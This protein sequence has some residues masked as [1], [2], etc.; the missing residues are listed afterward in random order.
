MIPPHCA[1]CWAAYAPVI[2]DAGLLDTVLDI[3]KGY[4]THSLLAGHRFPAESGKF[5]EPLLDEAGKEIMWLEN[6]AFVRNTAGAPSDLLRHPD[7]PPGLA[8]RLVGQCKHTLTGDNALNDAMLQE[9][10][11]TLGVNATSS[12]V[13][14]E[15]QRQRRRLG[16]ARRRQRHTQV[17]SSPGK[18]LALVQPLRFFSPAL[19]SRAQLAAAA[20]P[21]VRVNTARM[22]EL[23]MWHGIGEAMNKAAAQQRQERA[24][25]LWWGFR[26]RVPRFPKHLELHVRF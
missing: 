20:V 2:G 10:E 22:Q 26:S 1:S 12:Q 18:T 11:K 9:E 4:V 17:L 23:R 16:F 5:S 19:A 25:N 21:E 15:A 7:H 6:A 14:E 13:A 24:F 8:A 3:P